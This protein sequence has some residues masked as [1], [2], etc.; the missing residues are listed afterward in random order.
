MAVIPMLKACSKCGALVPNTEEVMRMNI[1]NNFERGYKVKC[2]KC[3]A[4]TKDFH[5][6]LGAADAWN[7]GKVYGD[8]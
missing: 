2:L 8:T 1:K 5:T 3:G 6:K 7:D 4:E